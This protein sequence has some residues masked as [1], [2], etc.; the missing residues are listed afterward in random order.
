MTEAALLRLLS[1]NVEPRPGRGGW[2]GGPTPLG[3]LRGVSPAAAHWRP[4]PGRHS[5]WALTLHVAYWTYAV[6]RR[7][8]GGGPAFTRSPA[9]FPKVPERP[10]AR[11]WAADR[12]LL[13]EER[14]LL[15]EAIRAVPSSR[16]GRRPAGAKKWTYGE[17]IT[18]IAQHD[19]YHTGQIQML[20]R[21]WRAR[22][23]LG[24]A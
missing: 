11:A 12:A 22:R 2:H 5:I 4:A 19:A 13:A 16:L 1:E 7:I 15:L 23:S 14:R 10:S 17:L 18:G 8:S 9:N 3:A 6:R 24:R 21:L 20:K